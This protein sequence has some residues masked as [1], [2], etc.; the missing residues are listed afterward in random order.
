MSKTSIY[1]RS[2]SNVGIIKWQFSILSYHTSKIEETNRHIVTGTLAIANWLRTHTRQRSTT[3]SETLSD[4]LSDND[5]SVFSKSRTVVL[6]SSMVAIANLF[7][8][9]LTPTYSWQL[10]WNQTNDQQFYI[11]KFITPFLQ[12][13]AAG[14]NKFYTIFYVTENI[15]ETAIY[16]FE[17]YF[18]ELHSIIQY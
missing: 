15:F 12:F 13:Y 5:K 10:M 17:I 6:T 14:W 9:F 8:Q 4:T 11:N 16:S 1:Q 7:Q 2:S 3:L 18:W